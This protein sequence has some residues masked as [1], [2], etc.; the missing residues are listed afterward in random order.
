MVESRLIFPRRSARKRYSRD[1]QPPPP[2][3][4][5]VRDVDRSGLG[6]AFRSRQPAPEI[7]YSGRVFGEC[8]RAVLPGSGRVL[9]SSQIEGA[10][11]PAEQ[12]PPKK[13]DPAS[14][15]PGVRALW[16]EGD[17]AGFRADASDTDSPPF[18]IMIPPPNVTG[19]LHGGHALNNT[20]QDIIVRW[21]RMRG[22]NTLWMPGTD[23]VPDD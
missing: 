2:V 23:H 21:S 17:H 19:A 16:A 5:P 6:L 13:Y 9:G 18:T 14:V 11:S 1:L 20:L 4:G 15:E 3:P 10:M 7:R 22:C 8:Y 12:L